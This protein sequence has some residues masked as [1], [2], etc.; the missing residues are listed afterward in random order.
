[1][2]QGEGEREEGGG[3]GKDGEGRGGEYTEDVSLSVKEFINLYFASL[4]LRLN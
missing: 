4:H 3:A 1:M 2:G